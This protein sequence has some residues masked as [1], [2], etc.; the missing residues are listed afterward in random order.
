MLRRSS[1]RQHGSALSTAASS[2]SNQ[3][4]HFVMR[5]IIKSHVARRRAAAHAPQQP[6]RAVSHRNR[7]EPEVHHRPSFLQQ[8]SAELNSLFAQLLV[9]STPCLL[10]SLFAQLLVCSTPCL[11]N[12][13]F[14]MNDAAY[15]WH[16]GFNSMVTRCT[17]CPSFLIFASKRTYL[18]R[19]PCDFVKCGAGTERNG[20]KPPAAQRNDPWTPSRCVIFVFTTRLCVH[21]CS[22][23]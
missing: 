10:N 14:A 6:R 22:V 12:S 21:A 18:Q 16:D 11:L 5:I 17:G 15:S 2:S 1:R 20:R 13:L 9:C 3:A 23:L 7:Q 8:V 19:L 4:L